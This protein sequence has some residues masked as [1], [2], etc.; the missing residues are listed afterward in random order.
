MIDATS[1]LLASSGAKTYMYHWV[2]SLLGSSSQDSIL[3]FPFFGT[4]SGLD[5]RRSSAG[6][7]RTAMGTGAVGF[8]NIKWNPV[9]EILGAAADVFHSSQH[10]R[11]PPNRATRLT[12]T[13]FDMTCW[14][15]PEVHTPA[16]VAATREYGERVLR[17]AIASIAIS[18]QSKKDAVEILKLPPDSIDVIYPGVADEFFTVGRPEAQAVTTKY[19]LDKPY[20]L[21]LGTIEPRKNIDRLLDAYES[22]CASVAREHELVIAGPFGW[23]SDA[24]KARL[25]NPK[26]GIRYLGYVSEADLPGLTAGATALV[27]ASL[28]EGFGL[29]LVQAMA[30]GVPAITSCNSSLREVAGDDTI[31]VDPRNTE[32]ITAAMGRL[33]LSSSLREDLS[34]RGRL[35]AASFRWKR[36]AERS[37]AFFHKLALC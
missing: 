33:A 20:F 16:N 7:L 19:R 5:H 34:R 13:I 26:A 30:S 17:R 36:N 21:Y 14:T 11:N 2:K 29:P 8:S 1:L 24:T 15:M 37:L 35:R 22:L 23:C 10:L 18:E 12:A 3:L 6:R 4:F 32:A 25:R 9:L 27:Y 31:L 28:Y